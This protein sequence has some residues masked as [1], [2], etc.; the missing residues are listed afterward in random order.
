MV[1]EMIIQI[2]KAFTALSKKFFMQKG[3]RATA[4]SSSSKPASEETKEVRWMY[5]V[6][7]D[8]WSLEL[9]ESKDDLKS[10]LVGSLPQEDKSQS[11][12]WGL[13]M[14]WAKERFEFAPAHACVTICK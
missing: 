13:S 9:G 1:H 11:D 14:I 8:L 7:N 4:S 6:D 5:M 3:R 12:P 10:V 2:S